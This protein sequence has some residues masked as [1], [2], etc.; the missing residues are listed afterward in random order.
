VGRRPRLLAADHDPEVRRHLPL[1]I[2]GRFSSNLLLRFP[3]PFLGVI[4]AGLG[5]SVGVMGVALSAGE[6]AGL[7]APAVGRAAD[8]RGARTAMSVGLALVTGGALLAAGAP[9]VVVFAVAMVVV[10]LS[11]VSFDAATTSWIAD[12]VPF[13][14]RSE[15]TGLVETSWAMAL[16]VGIPVLG[17]VVDRF[18]W[19][20]GY[21]VIAVLCGLAAFGVRSRI[22]RGVGPHPGALHP[23]ALLDEAVGGPVAPTALATVAD[24]PAAMPGAAWWKLPARTVATLAAVALLM[25]AVQLVVVVEGVWFEDAFGFSTARIGGAVLFIGIAEL[26]GSLGSSR[27]TDRVGKRRSMVLGALVMLPAMA[28]LGLVGSHAPLG[29]AVLSVGTLGFEYALVSAFPLVAE[30]DPAARG[31][32]FTFMLAAGTA[33]RGV[34]DA[35]GAILYDAGG[36]ATVGLTSAVVVGVVLVLL[37]VAVREP[38]RV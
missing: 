15:V 32:M 34:A 33:L 9:G 22:P 7:A 31:T 18:G 2:G 13:G 4:A 20:W 37:A 26:I 27:L 14:R 23:D 25:G 35:V 5:T 36:I 28:A 3:A 12:R 19:R 30:L 10:Q 16:L 21:L 38:G 24:A 11:K 6:F 1:L 29:I 8:R 17:L